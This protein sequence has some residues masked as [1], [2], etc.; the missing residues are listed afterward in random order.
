[1]CKYCAKAFLGNT[2]PN[3]FSHHKEISNT[4]LCEIDINNPVHLDSE[5]TGFAFSAVIG[6]EHVQDE[7]YFQIFIE[8]IYDGQQ[9]YFYRSFPKYNSAGSVQLSETP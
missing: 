8:V 2:I 1:L 4:N 9:I 5:K 3:C 7:H 6:T